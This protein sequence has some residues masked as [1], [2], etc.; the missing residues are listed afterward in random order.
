MGEGERVGEREGE[1]ERREGNAA[2]N[3]DRERPI[4][5]GW[6]SPGWLF[7]S[8]SL[9]PFFFFRRLGIQPP[10]SCAVSVT[11]PAARDYVTHAAHDAA[12]FAR[13]L[14]FLLSFYFALSL[15]GSRRAR[16]RT[17]IQLL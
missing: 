4:S 1:G 3:A 15:I 9:L 13:A 8:F 16:A 2:T 7:S 10:W 14:F 5:R 6:C 12:N 17:K 11:S